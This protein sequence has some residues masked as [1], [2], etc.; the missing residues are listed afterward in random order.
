MTAA[1]AL[2]HDGAMRPRPEVASL[3]Y[4]EIT[5]ERATSGFQ[6]PGALPFSLSR[7]AFALSL[8]AVATSP[9]APA[10]ATELDLS[11]PGRHL[12]LTFDDGGKS[13]LYAADQ[14]T[15]RGW[16]GH[17]FIVTS[18]IGSRTFL[19]RQEI[20]QLH[21]GGHLIGSHSHTH[22]SFFSELPLDRM[23]QEWRISAEVLSDLTGAPCQAASVPA[24][25]ISPAVLESGAGAGFRF[26]FT[27]EPELRPRWS[28]G[29]WVLGRGLVKR[30][31]SGSQV[32]DLVQF[33]GWRRAM[34][35]RR[36][37]VLARQACPPLYHQVVR[38]RTR[39]WE[40]GEG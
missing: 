29:C 2:S 17:F 33:R 9:C 37:K 7:A 22:P 34:A 16:R 36:L 38:R 20:R 19:T 6:R 18:L 23:M 39:S 35:L 21:D 30:R 25:D 28:N 27:V 4:H 3:A 12:L 1:L 40:I 10:L 26:L 11:R 14:L 32:R 31:T 13:A 8:E 24:G 15:R 5:D